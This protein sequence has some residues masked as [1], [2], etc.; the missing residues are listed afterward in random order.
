MITSFDQ[1]DLDKQYSYQDYCSWQFEDRVELH[2][3]YVVRLFP[4]P[5]RRH[6]AISGRI[7]AKLFNFLDSSDTCEVYSAPFDV[8]LSTGA[9]AGDT[10]VQP[11]LCVICDPEKLT[12]QG[13]TGAPD[14]IVEILAPSNIKNDLRDKFS[15]YE[16]AGV[17]EY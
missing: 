17:P 6:Q 16:A 2:R 8:R 14:I 13:C 1:L 7:H 11:D 4:G 10:V 12:V 9:A 15:L 3:G 5:N